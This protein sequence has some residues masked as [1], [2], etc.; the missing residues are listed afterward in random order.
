MFS[1]GA[2]NTWDEERVYIML[3]ITAEAHSGSQIN[4]CI[5]QAITTCGL[6][7]LYLYSGLSNEQLRHELRSRD[8]HNLKIDGE[9]VRT[10]GVAE[11]CVTFDFNDVKVTV[12][13]DSDKELIYRDWSRALDG[14]IDKAV[15]PYPDPALTDEEL[16]HDAEVDA[17]RKR[18]QQQWQAKYEAEADAHSERVDARLVG[19]PEMGFSDRDSW[20][21]A[22]PQLAKSIYGTSIATYAERWARLMQLELSEGKELADIWSAASTEADLEGMSGNSAGI[23]THL[24]TETWVHGAELRRLHN[25]YWGSDS[26]EGTVNPA[27]I[28]INKSGSEPTESTVG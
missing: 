10:H 9:F 12:K 22:L 14:K 3:N 13:V 18:K 8:L 5:S 1:T 2:F 11:I 19:A 23:A 15:G 24:L 7:H 21:K 26:T 20:D 17:E 16:A 27:I 25:T 4:N 28:T 6:A